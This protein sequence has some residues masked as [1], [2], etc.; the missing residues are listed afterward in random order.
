MTTAIGRRS[1]LGGL[2]AGGATIALT[3]LP[4]PA[5]A[6]TTALTTAPGMPLYAQSVAVNAFDSTSSVYNWKASNTRRHR[7]GLALAQ[8]GGATSEIC[9]GDSL[10]AG[11]LNVYTGAFDRAHAWPMIYRDTLASLGIR[12]NGTGIVR[13]LDYNYADP[14]VTWTGPWTNNTTDACVS[15]SGATATFTTDKAGTAVGVLYARAANSGGFTISVNGATSG[16][17]F[18]SVAGGGSGWARAELTGLSLAPGSRI[19]VTTTSASMVRL[20]GFEVYTP[21]G[22]LSVH[23][24]AQ[25][26]S[27]AV[28][29]AKKGWSTVTDLNQNLAMWS[30]TFGSLFLQTPSTVHLALGGNDL[31]NGSTDAA[32]TAGLTTIRKAFPNSDCFLYLEPRPNSATDARW[33]TWCSAMYALADALDV[34]LFDIEDRLGGY[35][36]ESTLGMNGDTFGHLSRAGYADWGRSV[37]M[38]AAR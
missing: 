6:A 11:C 27:G 7:S 33:S 36:I 15:S 34:P 26:G 32:I 19:T 25:S 37:A 21:N 3:A 1:F 23:N 9:I 8:S 14:R 16:A 30:G 35:A 22:G 10:T 12:S 31:L 5:N 29:P 13:I 20:A 17:G 28:L 24:I 38:V 4:S 18:R 2:G